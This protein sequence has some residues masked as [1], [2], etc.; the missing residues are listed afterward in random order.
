MELMFSSC[1]AMSATEKITDYAIVFHSKH[2]V[3]MSA[4]PDRQPSIS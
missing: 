4:S 3:T 1:V 2:Y